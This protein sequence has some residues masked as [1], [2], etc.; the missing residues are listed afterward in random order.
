[1]T[2]DTA[3]LEAALLFSLATQLMAALLQG[4]NTKKHDE[5]TQLKSLK[6]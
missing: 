1:M 2:A 5:F 3:G 6:I 4:L